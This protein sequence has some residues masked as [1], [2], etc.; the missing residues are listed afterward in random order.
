MNNKDKYINA[1]KLDY[2]IQSKERG[3]I[4]YY[5]IEQVAALLN[6]SIDNI[7]YYTNIFYDLLR[8]EIVDKELHFTNNDVDKL[9]S[10]IK[11]KNKGMS[12]KEIEEYFSKLPLNDGDAKNKENNLLSVEEL[13]DSIKIEQELYFK[14]FKTQ[15][16][17]DIQA[18][19]LLYLQNITYTFIEAQNKNIIEIKKDLSK[20]I[21]QYIDLKIPNINE[22]NISLHEKLIENTNKIISEKLDNKNEEIRLS[23]QNDFN[24]FV[25]LSS[26]NEEALIKEVKDFKAVIKNAYYIE[27]EVSEDNSKISFWK[28]L[29]A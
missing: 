13:I 6:E 20:E 12:N 22:V 23:L 8:I 4:L 7:K 2:K 11:F 25:K 27:S 1:Q 17:N 10:L 29:F 24:N 3:E 26:N 5:S 9:E 21:K 14:D 19:N 15:L 16:L 18:S 28:K